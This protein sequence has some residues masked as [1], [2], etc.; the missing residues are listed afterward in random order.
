VVVADVKATDSVIAAR[1]RIHRALDT[2]VERTEWTLDKVRGLGLESRLV[3]WTAVAAVA[4]GLVKAAANPHRCNTVKISASAARLAF[5][6]WPAAQRPGWVRFGELWAFANSSPADSERADAGT[7]WLAAS[8]AELWAELRDAFAAMYPAAQLAEH[9]DGVRVSADRPTNVRRL[10]ASER[11]LAA[12]VAKYVDASVSTSVLLY[13]PQGSAKTTAACSIASIVCGSYFRMSADHIG[14]EEIY[15]LV[16]L[17]PRAVV[18][19]D[20]DRVHDVALLELLDTLKSAGVFVFATSNTSPDARH[21]DGDLMD[22]A[23]VRSGRFD[24]HHPV[25][26]LDPDSH[27]QICRDNGLA[28]VDLGPRA[29]ELLA[30]DLVA[31]G[32]MHRAHDLPNPSDAAEDLLLRRTNT[33]RRLQV[34]PKVTLT[35]ITKPG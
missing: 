30:S 20:I 1:I 17:R 6:V 16:D 4:A 34:Q 22:A 35:A 13:G 10:T 28:G 33:T 18:I 25:N 19:D 8:E 29:G 15:A 3:R 11:D 5:A 14:S 26:Q 24:I 32:R 9:R 21:G 27:A 7:V 23:L 2:F 31:L 12:R